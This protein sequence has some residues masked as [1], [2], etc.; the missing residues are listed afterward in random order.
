MLKFNMRSN[1]LDERDFKY[2]LQD[3]DKPNLFRDLFPYD[4]VPKIAFNNRRVPMNM[5]PSI[6]LTDT[7]FRDGQQ[8][9][10][11]YSAKNMVDLF[12]MMHQLGGPEGIIRQT[13]FFAYSPADRKAI[14][15]CLALGYAY[16]QITTWIRASKKD[17]ELVKHIGVKETGILVSC[18]DY[19]IYKKL[20]M[21]R[22]QALSHYLGVVSEIFEQGL[23]PRCHFE[24][25]TR[26]DYYGFVVPF[27]N[28]LVK[29]SN[30]AEMPVKIRCC[31][32]MGYGVPFSGSSLPR[33]VPGIIYGLQ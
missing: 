16:P 9:R 12:R 3:S 28:E 14:E 15:D 19:H 26:A 21:T 10:A 8:S 27:V 31:D 30:A 18:S 7:T 11:P 5:P 20:K 33:S 29:L 23:V 32:T 1:L 22:G 2:P 25:I 24:D 6:W 17:F 4:E 13:E